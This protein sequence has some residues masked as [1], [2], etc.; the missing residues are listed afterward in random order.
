M[1]LQINKKGCKNMLA[2]GNIMKMENEKK[3]DMLGFV[4]KKIDM[5]FAVKIREVGFRRFVTDGVA[6]EI[7]RNEEWIF[8]H[9]TNGSFVRILER[10]NGGKKRLSIIVTPKVN[11]SKYMLY[12][13]TLAEV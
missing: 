1:T 6:K 11:P 10:G 4:Q 3:F 9:V 8:V 12:V 13:R 5:V 2:L 7:G